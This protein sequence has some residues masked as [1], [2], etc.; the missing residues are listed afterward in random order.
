MHFACIREGWLMYG[1]GLLGSKN[2]AVVQVQ[3]CGTE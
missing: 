2:C 3:N 1:Y